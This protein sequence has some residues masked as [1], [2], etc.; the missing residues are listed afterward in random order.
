VSKSDLVREFARKEYIEP[1][2]LRKDEMIRV[3]AGDV[4]RALKL[5]GRTPLV[6][7][8]LSGN[9]FLEENHLILQDREGPPSGISTTVVFVYRLNIPSHGESTKSSPFLLLR[10]AGKEVFAALGGGEAFLHAERSR[11]IK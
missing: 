4:Q 3:R 10:G 8:A 6:C 2:R 5:E 9:K 1:A 11:F 7:Q